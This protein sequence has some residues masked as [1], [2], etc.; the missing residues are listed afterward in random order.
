MN[1]QITV[2]LSTC[3]I[4]SIHNVYMYV[5][6]QKLNMV[7]GYNGYFSKTLVHLNLVDRYCQMYMYMYMQMYVLYMH[8]HVHVQCIYA[9]KKY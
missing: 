9:S 6:W 4:T 8:V 7:V 3:I 5:H 2:Q 1:L